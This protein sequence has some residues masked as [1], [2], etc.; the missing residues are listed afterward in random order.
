MKLSTVIAV[1]AAVALLGAPTR[2]LAAGKV[3]VGIS[4]TGEDTVG[5]QLAFALREAV[6]RSAGYELV[7]ERDA[8]L[9]IH[10]V[11]LEPRENAQ[12]GWTVTSVV[13][14][15]QNRLALEPRDPQTWYPIFLTAQVAVSG[16]DAVPSIALA[17][18]GGL[19]AAMEDFRRDARSGQ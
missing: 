8:L 17:I 15:M 5:S 7:P 3:N 18:L 9:T 12:G 1:S 11:T 13:Y 6:R 10:L 14:T 19:D 2:A 4:H 16:R